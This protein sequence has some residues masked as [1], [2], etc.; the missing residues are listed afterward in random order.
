M[1]LQ[2]KISIWLK[3][4]LI[5]NNLKSCVIGISGGIDSAVSSTLCAMT[6]FKTYLVVMPINQ[7]PDETNRGINHCTWLENQFNNVETINIE[8][9]NTYSTMKETVPKNFH[10]ELALAN[11][12]ARIRMS[13]LYMIA[14]VKV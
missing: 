1:N 8:L 13:V 5:D 3:N 12:R 7:N 14:G 10:N 11:T 9:S 6:G 2:N 4:Y